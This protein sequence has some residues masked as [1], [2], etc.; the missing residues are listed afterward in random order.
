MHAGQSRNKPRAA[1]GNVRLKGFV[2]PLEVDEINRRSIEGELT[3][4]QHIAAIAALF[5]AT[6]DNISVPIGTED[7]DRAS[8]IKN[9]RAASLFLCVALVLDV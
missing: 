3:G 1:R 6:N 7:V 5:N 8:A 2:L 4:D 9:C